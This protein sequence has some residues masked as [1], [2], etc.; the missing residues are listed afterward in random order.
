V[1]QG[2][3]IEAVKQKRDFCRMNPKHPPNTQAIAS[4]PDL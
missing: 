4:A 2:S 1:M 3:R